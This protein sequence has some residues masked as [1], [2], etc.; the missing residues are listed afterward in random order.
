[1]EV[2]RRLSV[3]EGQMRGSRDDRTGEGNLRRSLCE[4]TGLLENVDASCMEAFI[5]DQRGLKRE[6]YEMFKNHPALLV[7]T[8][9]QLSKSQ[10]RQ[11]VRDCL[12]AILD[13]GLKPLHYFDSDLKRYFYMAEL[14]APV[15]LS[16]V[17]SSWDCELPLHLTQHARAST[18]FC[19][20][21]R[22]RIPGSSPCIE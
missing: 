7:P 13:A 10:H 11:L 2:Q 12:H 22:C 3:L 8:V 16:L 14:C 6:V 20:E 19:D 9:E 5:D 15:D 1:M 18:A 4:S 21:P 17:R